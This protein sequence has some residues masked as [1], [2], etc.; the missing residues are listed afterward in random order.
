MV[1][2][3][4]PGGLPRDSARSASWQAAFIQ[5]AAKAGRGTRPLAPQ[6]VIDCYP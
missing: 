6:F 4:Q 3:V 2:I 5:A 1:G